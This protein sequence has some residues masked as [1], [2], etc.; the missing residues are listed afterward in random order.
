MKKVL[1]GWKPTPTSTRTPLSTQ[2][3]NEPRYVLKRTQ[4]LKEEEDLGRTMS[5][6][7]GTSE[8]NAALPAKT[9]RT[10]K[11]KK[12]SAERTPKKKPWKAA[13]ERERNAENEITLLQN[14]TQ[15]S[16]LRLRKASRFSYGES[17]RTCVHCS[18][19][20]L[21]ELHSTH[22]TIVWRDPG[23]SWTCLP[24]VY[25]SGW[26]HPATGCDTR[27]LCP[28]KQSEKKGAIWNAKKYQ[29]H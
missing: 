19:L 17:P 8:K 7:K 5:R 18:T 6:K 20:L 16:C 24:P 22:E 9:N 4:P 29:N 25:S 15:T 21:R 28:E 3:R 26:N 2:N 27:R 11:R 13:L 10:T 1:A 12:K 14:A 23:G